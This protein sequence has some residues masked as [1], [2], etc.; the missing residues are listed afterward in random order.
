MEEIIFFD[1]DDT[2]EWLKEYTSPSKPKRQSIQNTVSKTTKTKSYTI[3][4]LDAEEF[5]IVILF[6]VGGF[7]LIILE[8]SLIGYMLWFFKQ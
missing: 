8:S 2:N 5:E 4:G 6:L 3:L 1:E 7:F